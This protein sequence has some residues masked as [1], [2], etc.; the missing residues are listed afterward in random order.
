MLTTTTLPVFGLLRKPERGGEQ[1]RLPGLMTRREWSNSTCTVCVRS[2]IIRARLL[3]H[4]DS[5]LAVNGLSHRIAR[6]SS[7]IH[8]SQV[9][10]A[11]SV[12]VMEMRRHRGRIEKHGL[13]AFIVRYNISITHGA[14][15]P[16]KT[17]EFLNSASRRS[18]FIE[19]RCPVRAGRIA[20]V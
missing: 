9:G 19:R 16:I 8:C 7:F 1:R 6:I 11:A 14:L 3:K 2:P 15:S 4:T 5:S 10:I 13:S 18:Q 20:G 17:T 12:P